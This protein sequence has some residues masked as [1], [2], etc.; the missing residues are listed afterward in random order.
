LAEYRIH[1]PE[2]RRR[3][4][5]LARLYF[6]SPRSP[7]CILYYVFWISWIL[8]IS[9]ANPSNVQ[10]LSIATG[11]T[12]GVYYAYGG[13]LAKVVSEHVPGVRATAEST[14]ASVD[15]LKLIRDGQADVA[16]TL[17]DTAADAAAGR[18]PFAGARPVGARALAVLYF[19]YLH[20]VTLDA[21][22][23]SIQD[24]RGRVVA[25]GLPGSGT[26]VTA[27]RVLA[28]VGIDPDRDVTLFW[29]GGLP[30][31]AFLDLAH[32]PNV[33]MRLVPTAPALDSLKREYGALYTQLEIPSGTYRGIDVA[34]PVVGVANLLV[35]RADMPEDLAYRLTRVLFENQAELAAVHPEA[36]KLSLGTAVTGSPLEYH[37]GAVRYYRERKAMR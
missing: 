33:H 28:A 34:V 10:Y 15:N 20:L 14:A 36:K 21:A 13:G 3:S 7:F 9:C 23:T 24:L 30:T 19:N 12:G 29:S 35:V 25:T 11:D 6:S 16:F 22:L 2:Y 5:R 32:S 17:A 26:E 8:S 4:A 1:N 37:A 27:R 31:P 18:G